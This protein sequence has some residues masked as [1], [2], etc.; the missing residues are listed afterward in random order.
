MNNDDTVKL[1]TT[2]PDTELA[3]ELK[4][5]LTKAAEPWL[6]ACTKANKAGFAIQSSF[7]PDYLGRYVIQQLQLI[8][9][10]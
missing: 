10:Y 5:E 7:A 8:K 2:K 1:V 3:K 6:E 9:I 4:A